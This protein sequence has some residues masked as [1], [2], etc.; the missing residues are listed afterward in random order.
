MPIISNNG[1]TNI[2]E[3]INEE[4]FKMIEEKIIKVS[5]NILHFRDVEL[6]LIDDIDEVSRYSGEANFRF[7]KPYS[8]TK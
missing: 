1:N 8:L 5:Q 3:F 2:K 4:R 7:K 6:G